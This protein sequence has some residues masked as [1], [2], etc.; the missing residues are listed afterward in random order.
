MLPFEMLSYLLSSVLVP[1]GAGNLFL[2]GTLSVH[3]T[4]L[5]ATRVSRDRNVVCALLAEE[6]EIPKE[7]VQARRAS[8]SNADTCP[9]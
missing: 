3:Y 8:I 1:T 5:L 7:F 4:S 9:P 2:L 6:G